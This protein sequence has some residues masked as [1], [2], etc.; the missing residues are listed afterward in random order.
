MEYVLIVSVR[1]TLCVCNCQMME[2]ARVEDRHARGF[3]AGVLRWIG[4]VAV[5]AM[6]TVTFKGSGHYVGAGMSLLDDALSHSAGRVSKSA[7][8]RAA[9]SSGSKRAALFFFLLQ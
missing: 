8:Q 1:G 6:Q 5:V 2:E 7:P 3:S 9:K 4:C